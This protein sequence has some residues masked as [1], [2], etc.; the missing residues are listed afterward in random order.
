[1]KK[2]QA[3]LRLIQAK[4]RHRKQPP[5]LKKK[6]QILPHPA[7]RSH[8]IAVNAIPHHKNYQ[9]K[10]PLSFPIQSSLGRLQQ[11]TRNGLRRLE[12]QASRINELSTELEAAVLELKAIASQVNRDLKALQATQQPRS[13]AIAPKVCE[14]RAANLPTVYQKPS[15]LFVLTSRSVDLFKAEREAKVLAQVLRHR[16]RRKRLI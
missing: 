13:K 8:L 4:F 10:A 6:P 11:R 5:V 3:G 12:Y 16:A 2:L 15:G 9:S 14:Y 1:M 7:Y